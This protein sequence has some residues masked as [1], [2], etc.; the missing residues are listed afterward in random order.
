M[1]HGTL[2]GQKCSALLNIKITENNGLWKI[3]KCVT[4]LS[5]VWK[6]FVD[7]A[8]QGFRTQEVETRAWKRK[9][10]REVDK[11]RTKQALEK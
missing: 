1:D 7:L 6:L 5:L 3:S 11:I 4:R 10:N 9:I 8:K 2:T